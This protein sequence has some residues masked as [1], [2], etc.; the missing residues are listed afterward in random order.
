MYIYIYYIYI[1]IYTYIYIIYVCIL[2]MYIVIE[3]ISSNIRFA[4]GSIQ[5]YP[6]LNHG[7][8]RRIQVYS[9]GILF[10]L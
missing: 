4:K 10:D 2:Y 6:L 5:L 9:K 3:I 1:Y 8:T 7:S